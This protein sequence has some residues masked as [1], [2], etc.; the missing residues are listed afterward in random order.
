MVHALEEI[1]RLLRPGGYLVEIHPFPEGSLLKVLRD[2]E[3]LF[4]E[5]RR[6]SEDEDVLH[7]EEAVAEV[8]GRHLF[9]IEDTG[10]FD[11]FTYASSVPELREF[12]EEASAYDDSPKDEALEAREEELYRQAEEIM[13]ATGEGAEVATHSRAWIGRLR[14]VR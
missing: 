12:K 3:I 13:Q 5:P 8:V 1:H 9:V 6:L 10:E 7:A 2:G 14:P 4:A 11:F